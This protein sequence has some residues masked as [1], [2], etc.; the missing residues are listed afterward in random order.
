MMLCCSRA[1]I[2]LINGIKID[3][4]VDTGSDVTIVSEDVLKKLNNVDVMRS[5][6]FLRGLRKKTTKPIGC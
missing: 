4:L 5:Q 2:I 3:C 6:T 1:K